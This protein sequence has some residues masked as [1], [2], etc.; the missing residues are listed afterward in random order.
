ML[1]LPRLQL[2]QIGLE[3]FARPSD[4]GRQRDFHQLRSKK[5]Y[6]F[7]LVEWIYN[8]PHFEKVYESDR[9]NVY[10]LQPAS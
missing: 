9:F 8:S 10:R 4:Q 3:R 2:C 5:T 1:P 6:Y 7:K